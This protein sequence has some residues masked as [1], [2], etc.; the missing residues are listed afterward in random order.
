[1]ARRLVLATSAFGASI[2]LV[3]AC[4]SFA[5]SSADPD[6]SASEGGQDAFAP[7][8]PSMGPSDDALPPGC[9]TAKDFVDEGEIQTGHTGVESARLVSS[10]RVYFSAQPSGAS[11]TA[12]MFFAIYT[13]GTFTSEQAYFEGISWGAR[14][15]HP[16]A[17]D[18]EKA[19]IFESNSSGSDKLYIVRRLESGVPFVGTSPTPVTVANDPPFTDVEEPWLVD[20]TLYFSGTRQ[21]LEDELW[22]GTLED[23]QLK[24]V[25]RI[26]EL[27]PDA[28]GSF[29]VGHPVVTLDQRKIYFSRVVSA[30]EKSDIVVAE[31]PAPNSLFG[32]PKKLGVGAV[33]T[34][35]HPTWISPDDCVL[36]YVTEG[37]L[38][39]ARRK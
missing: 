28:T 21:N 36:W 3:I 27:A 25:K 15:L 4:G 31:R 32:P 35:D 11:G 5:T 23:T 20:K 24:D 2:G 19:V 39:R 37:V 10:D 9:D 33:N 38:R 8:G 16:F 14:D 34:N 30:A 1:M 12:K 6:A 13:A 22:F 18:S 17:F 26:Q 7:D 29:S